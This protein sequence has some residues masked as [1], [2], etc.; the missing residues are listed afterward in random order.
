M[1]TRL[2]VFTGGKNRREPQRKRM[3][4]AFQGPRAAI[5]RLC[6]DILPPTPRGIKDSR[7]SKETIFAES[8]EAFFVSRLEGEMTR[9]YPGHDNGSRAVKY[10]SSG[11]PHLPT[12]SCDRN[13]V[14]SAHLRG[15]SG[16]V[17]KSYRPSSPGRS[18]KMYTK[19]QSTAQCLQ[20][21]KNLLPN[22]RH[23]ESSE[24]RRTI[25]A[26]SGNT[27]HISSLPRSWSWCERPS[28]TS[29]TWRASSDPLRQRRKKTNRCAR[30]SGSAAEPD[31]FPV[32]RE[33]VC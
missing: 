26:A 17:G 11:K 18:F 4:Q 14:S 23:Q 10:S 32:A 24:V 25:T 28:P 6:L 30:H 13:C 27:Y 22:A 1:F 9:A 5:S 21:L 8:S 15:M 29:L 19:A 31:V 3:R 16:G 7:T 20:I 2:S 12:L 33:S